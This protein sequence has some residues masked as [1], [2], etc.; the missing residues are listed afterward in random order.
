MRERSII[1]STVVLGLI[2]GAGLADDAPADATQI[3][4]A[5]DGVITAGCI[6]TGTTPSG[7]SPRWGEYNDKISGVSDGSR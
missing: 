3:R 5:P 2:F 1:L 7:G 4:A 6:G